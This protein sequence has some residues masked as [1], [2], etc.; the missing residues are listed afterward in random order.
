MLDDGENKVDD[1]GTGEEASGS[2]NESSA[3]G[4]VKLGAHVGE[5][6]LKSSSERQR[7]SAMITRPVAKQRSASD[8]DAPA[9]SQHPVKAYKRPK[10]QVARAASMNSSNMSVVSSD[11]DRGERT[12]QFLLEEQYIKLVTY[13]AGKKVEGDGASKPVGT[14]DSPKLLRR[15]SS[16]RKDEEASA[17]ALPSTADESEIPDTGWMVAS[18]LTAETMVDPSDRDEAS[19]PHERRKTDPKEKKMNERRI[20][21]RSE[22]SLPSGGGPIVSAQLPLQIHMPDVTPPQLERTNSSPLQKLPPLISLDIEHVND[23]IM[24]DVV[25]KAQASVVPDLGFDADASLID[26]FSL[27]M[28]ET[29]AQIQSCIQRPF[30]ERLIQDLVRLARHKMLV[31]LEGT[32]MRV[33][34]DLLSHRQA[35]LS[36]RHSAV[37]KQR[38]ESQNG[39]DTSRPHQPSVTATNTTRPSSIDSDRELQQSTSMLPLLGPGCLHAYVVPAQAGEEKIGDGHGGVYLQK[40]NDSEE[41]SN[42]EVKVPGDGID[43]CHGTP[44]VLFLGVIDWLQPYNTRKRLEHSFKGLLHDSKGISVQEPS[45]YARRFMRFMSKIFVDS[46]DLMALKQSM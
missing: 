6:G 13:L 37:A 41:L 18:T 45:T 42:G 7:K 23:G 5:H 25:R 12:W 16:Q 33:P 14:H 20:E 39:T 26:S 31:P 44:A 4:T 19:I 30:S 28:K 8:S 40:G 22:A 1:R 29:I 11:E 35:L 15:H 38:V 46:R 27:E 21:K 10:S 24:H 17:A 2:M 32:Q 34:T 9:S 43:A 36:D 3:F